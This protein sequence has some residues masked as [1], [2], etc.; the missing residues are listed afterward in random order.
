MTN[1][2]KKRKQQPVKTGVLDY[3]PDA[4]LAVAHCS[5]VGN[6]Q[7]NPGSELHW[8]RSKSG[9][10]LDALLRHLMGAGTIDS[11]GIRHSTKVAWRALAN[12]QKEIERERQEDYE[13]ELLEKISEDEKNMADYMY[14]GEECEGVLGSH[15]LCCTDYCPCK[16]EEIEKRMNII[17]RNGN[18]G[19]HYENPISSYPEPDS[20][21]VAVSTVKPCGWDN[22]NTKARRMSL[23]E[24]SLLAVLSFIVIGRSRKR[25]SILKD[26]TKEKRLQFSRGFNSPMRS[27]HDRVMEKESTVFGRQRKY[28]GSSTRRTL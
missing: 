3:F 2:A 5:Y 9:D 4:L 10:E 1:E 19:L 25:S 6:E 11:D 28:S 12:L 7:H 26:A 15:P 24:L 18:D 27:T 22:T 14:D 23:M 16:E 17:G 20:I 13:E 8:D 21:E